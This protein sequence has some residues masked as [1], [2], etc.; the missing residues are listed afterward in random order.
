MALLLTLPRRLTA[1][2]AVAAGLLIALPAAAADPA[3]GKGVFAAQCSMCHSS[4]RGG[5][6]ILGPTLFGVVG[7]PAGA[8]GGYNFSPAMKSA[9]FAWSDNKLHAYLAAP[10]KMLPGIKMAYGGVKNSAQL[11]DLVAYLD[12]LK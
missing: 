8:I 7:R 10:A 6:A 9:G 2:L 11:D 12:T 4:A 5:A 1:A 3:H